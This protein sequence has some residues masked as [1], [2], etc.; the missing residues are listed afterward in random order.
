MAQ[1]I[2]WAA[3]AFGAPGQGGVRLTLVDRLMS[4]G[5]GSTIARHCPVIFRR[6]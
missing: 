3:A 4:V 2:D 1:A 6:S 5:E